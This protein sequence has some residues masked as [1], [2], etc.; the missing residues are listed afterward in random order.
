MI[1]KFIQEQKGYNQKQVYDILKEE[2]D[3]DEKII[4]IMRKLK[5]YGILKLVK[6][7]VDKQR[8]MTD[9]ADA[10]VEVTDIE[11]GENDYSYVFSFVSIV[12]V[13]GKILKC[14]PKYISNN[15]E[16]IKEL[17]QIIKVLEKYNSKESDYVTTI[18]QL[19]KEIQ[20]LNTILNQNNFDINNFNEVNEKLKKL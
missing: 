7:D 10:Y 2:N 19:E 17:K 6:R 4:A 5:E 13:A 8:D 20:K 18:Y 11:I 3:N 9:L 12:T 1:S 15:Q 16:P 14:Y